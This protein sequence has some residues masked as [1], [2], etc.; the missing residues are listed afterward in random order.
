MRHDGVDEFYA[1]KGFVHGFAR[2]APAVVLIVV[3]AYLVGAQPW[4][5]AE[6]Y[7]AQ[8]EEKGLQ[9]WSQM[10]ANGSLRLHVSAENG[11][12][13]KIVEV[14]LED[15][16][17]CVIMGGS[18]AGGGEADLVARCG[19]GGA[20]EEYNGSVVLDHGGETAVGYFA[21]WRT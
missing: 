9:G 1:K 12:E 10:D 8:A 4:V 11:M 18:Q 21:G 20:G 16:R 3:V 19:P 7:E 2:L 15:G 17:K 5:K 13:P 6:K 14:R